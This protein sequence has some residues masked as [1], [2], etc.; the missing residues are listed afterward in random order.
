MEEKAASFRSGSMDAPSPCVG[1]EWQSLR[2]LK[3]SAERLF[4]QGEPFGDETLEQ[5]LIEK[6]D[7]T[8]EAPGLQCN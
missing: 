1:A 7:Q 2:Y 8:Y 6:S 4:Y 3:E 5:Q